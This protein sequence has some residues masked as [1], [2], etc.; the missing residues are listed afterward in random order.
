MQGYGT[1]EINAGDITCCYMLLFIGLLVLLIACINYNYINLITARSANRLREVGLRKVV[2][3]TRLQLMGQFL[4]ESL[5][6]V[7]LA[8][9]LAVLFASS[10]LPFFNEFMGV[11]LHLT[12][13]GSVFVLALS[14]CV[15]LGTGPGICL[16]GI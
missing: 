3:T 11:D 8:G 15:L 4:G 12:D 1:A 5:F 9:V 10:T 6:I 13:A 16:V 2:G 7:L 14:L